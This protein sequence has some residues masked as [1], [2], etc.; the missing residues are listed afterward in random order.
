MFSM[1]VVKRVQSYCI[2]RMD[3]NKLINLH[4]CKEN[5][6]TTYCTYAIHTEH[7]TKKY[8]NYGQIRHRDLLSIIILFLLFSILNL[9]IK[10]M[11]M[12]RGWAESGLNNGPM[13]LVWSF[14]YLFFWHITRTPSWEKPKTGFIIFNSIFLRWLNE[15]G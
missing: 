7:H 6:L 5:L 9:L 10:L 14:K 15:L 2:S 1:S 12:E 8:F 4:S 11:G 3:E 13:K